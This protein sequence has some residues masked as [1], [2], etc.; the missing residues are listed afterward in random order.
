MTPEARLR[1]WSHHRQLL[2]RRGTSLEQVL[3]AIIGVYSSHPSGRARFVD[4]GMQE[5]IYGSI[6]AT[7]GN[8]LGVVLVNG[9]AHGS[10][11]SRFQGNRMLVSMKMFEKMPRRM[12][13]PIRDRFREMASR[14][15]A[16]ELVLES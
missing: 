6:G 5:R 2:G 14:L 4:P 13:R 8:A 15:G 7:S 1:H 16:Q 10:W 12:E 9:L 3:A 11:S